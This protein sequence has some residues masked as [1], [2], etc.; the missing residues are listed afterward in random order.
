MVKI[1]LTQKTTLYTCWQTTKLKLAL[2]ENVQKC[3]LLL[4]ENK[5]KI[6]VCTY[7]KLVLNKTGKSSKSAHT[8]LKEIW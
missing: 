5:S 2:T 6:L 4:F 7:S 1:C 3:N 8:F